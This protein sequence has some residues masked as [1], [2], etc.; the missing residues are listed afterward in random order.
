MAE[1]DALLRVSMQLEVLQREVSELASR[2]RA[3]PASASA[4]APS[5]HPGRLSVLK[6]GLSIEAPSSE[7]DNSYL[8]PAHYTHKPESRLDGL[9][10]QAWSETPIFDA[11]KLDSFQ[12]FYNLSLFLLSFSLIYIAVRSF[13]EKGSLLTLDDFTCEPLIRDAVSAGAGA[14]AAYTASLLFFFAVYA[15][16]CRLITWAALTWTYGALQLSML[17]TTI[18]FLYLSPMS[19]MPSMILLMVVIVISL[20]A[21]SY[22]FTNYAIYAE[23]SIKYGGVPTAGRAAA[24]AAVGAARPDTASVVASPAATSP[25]KAGSGSS[26][27]PK[28]HLVAG[29]SESCAAAGDARASSS[30]DE[31]AASARSKGAKGPAPAPAAVDAAGVAHVP[32]GGTAGVEEPT[33]SAGIMRAAPAGVG[34]ALPAAERRSVVKAWPYNIGLV[35]F[36]YFLMAPTLV[37][38]PRFPRNR[39]RRWGYIVNKL[40][41]LMVCLL[42]QYTVMRQ[43]MLPVLQNPSLPRNESVA[44]SFGAYGFDMMKLAIPSL[45]VWLTGFY[46]IFHCWCNVLAELLRFPDREF[47]QDWWNSTTLD[48]FWRKWNKPVHEWCLRHI[49]IDMQQYTRASKQSAVIGVFVFSAIFHEVIFSVAFKTFRPWFLLGMLMQIPLILGG[50]CGANRRRGNYLVWL[51]VFCGQPLLELLYFREYFA[52]HE[53]FFCA[54]ERAPAAAALESVVGAFTETVAPWTGSGHRGAL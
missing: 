35:D 17:L 45:V 48:Q 27:R 39:F 42:M 11:L 20:K 21:H 15:W 37:Y 38:E 9:E 44:A 36:C 19:P 51:S 53:S 25:R 28:K 1:V 23:H 49:M 24:A 7:D 18:T 4:S 16:A 52:G 6:R 54:T 50:K 47:F 33:P 8:R 2:R 31:R 34:V 40:L 5:A 30:E 3:E 22:V 12:G 46:A 32:M 26:R 13:R 41:S 43:F 14:L 10:S 29:G